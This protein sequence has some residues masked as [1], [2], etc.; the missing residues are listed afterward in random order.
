MISFRGAHYPKDAIKVDHSTLNRWIIRYSPMIAAAAM[1]KKRP[2]ASS[3]RMDETYIKVKGQW[4]YLYRAVD[5]YGDTLDFMLSER[6]NEEAATRFFKQ[7]IDNNG[8]PNR[9]V[10]DKSG[11]NETG[12]LNMNI[13]L[14]LVGWVYLID[15]LQIKY[16]N[17]RIEQDHRFIKKLTN[18]MLGFKAFYSAQATLAGIETDH[19]IRKGQLSQIGIPAYRQFMAL[20]G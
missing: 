5:K 2:T 15:I 4:V 19:M 18:P 13:L 7:A 10:I 12:L 17:N 9:V 3:W 8:L 11:S 20:A 6:R 16:L 14:F 1:K